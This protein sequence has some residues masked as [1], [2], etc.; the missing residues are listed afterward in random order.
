MNYVAVD[1]GSGLCKFS[2]QSKRDFFPSIVGKCKKTNAFSIGL[3][4]FQQI[5]VN[6][7][8][9]L[10]GTAAQALL[11]NE[12]RVVT[13]KHSWSESDGHIILLYS[14]IA[15][16]YPEG[17]KGNLNLVTGLP[18][19]KYNTEASNFKNKITGIHKF[20]TPKYNYEI[21]FDNKTTVIL[22][23]VVGL[24]FANMLHN[25]GNWSEVKIGYIDPGTQTTGWA[26]MDEGVFQSVLSDGENIGLVKLAKEIKGYL[27]DR[28][29]YETPDD[30]QILKALT[31]GY[32][33]VRNNGKKE[34]VCLVEIANQYV[35]KVYGKMIDKIHQHWKGAKDMDIIVS[36]GGGKYLIDTLSRKFDGCNLLHP[37]TKTAK[38]NNQK[39]EAIFDVVEGYA[40]YAENALRS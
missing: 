30:T 26:V 3:K 28:F 9:W 1:V 22:P 21:E 10:T 39:K 27:R 18:I 14:A 34:N 16:L 2:S 38:K 11:N 5:I 24:H 33:E 19:K 23:Q 25:K 40:V 32:I 8:T 12:D 15:Y 4:D 6:G 17:F 13:T 7:D 20:S 31:K 29:E 35:P 37:D 36:S